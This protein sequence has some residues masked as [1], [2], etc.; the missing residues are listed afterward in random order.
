MQAKGLG[1]KVVSLGWYLRS[2]VQGLQGSPLRP[3][4][5][6]GQGMVMLGSLQAVAVHITSP[7]H[8]PVMKV[9]AVHPEPPRGFADLP[10]PHKLFSQHRGLELKEFRGASG[11]V[12]CH[13]T[14]WSVSLLPPA[15]PGPPQ[16]APQR[17]RHRGGPGVPP[18][19]ADEGPGPQAKLSTGLVEALKEL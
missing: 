3:A 7:H 2:K 18:W 12:S 1:F 11:P 16:R 9:S 17:P 10:W 8:G 6:R 19:A 14:L 4:G 15:P 5:H 13:K